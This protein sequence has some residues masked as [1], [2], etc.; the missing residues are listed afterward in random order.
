MKQL[1]YIYADSTVRNVDY[2]KSWRQQKNEGRRDQ[3]GNN[4]GS[5]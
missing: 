4:D 5:L 1:C 3:L 2:K